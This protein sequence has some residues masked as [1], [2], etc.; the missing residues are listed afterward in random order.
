[1]IFT[2]LIVYFKPFSK[3][4]IILLAHMSKFQNDRVNEIYLVENPP[5]KSETLYELIEKFNNDNPTS[6]GLFERLFIKEYD[7]EPSFLPLVGN[8][9]YKSKTSTKDDLHMRDFLGSSDCSIHFNGDTI[10]ETKMYKGD[11]WYY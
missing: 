10:C 2:S 9:D 5:W 1:M 6:N 3:T 7:Y 11:L 8:I 4:E